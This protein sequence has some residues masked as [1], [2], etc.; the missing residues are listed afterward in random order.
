VGAEGG[1]GVIVHYDGTVWTPMTVPGGTRGLFGV[2]GSSGNDVFAVGYR[3][4]LHYDVAEWAPMSVPFG[5]R[6]ILGVWGSSADH[7]FAVGSFGTILH[8]GV[9]TPPAAAADAYRTLSGQVLT[10]VAPGVLA[11]DMNAEGDHLTAALVATA[12]HGSLTLNADGSFRYAPAAGFA[13]QDFFTYK[14]ND[15]LA[16]S[17]VAKVTITVTAVPTINIRSP[18]GGQKWVRGTVHKIAWTT[19]VPGGTVCIKLYKGTR[20]YKT[21][22]AAAANTGAWSWRVARTLAAGTAYKVRV[23]LRAQPAV[24]DMSDRAFTLL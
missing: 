15:G 1:S 7:V 20:F 5:A 18:N 17:N 13:G 11:N 23:F 9:N 6:E 2:W 8:H 10:V 24:S 19:N 12:G 14:A 4:I 21:L 22:V 16:D 3:A